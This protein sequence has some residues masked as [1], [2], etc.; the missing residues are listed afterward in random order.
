MVLAVNNPLQPARSRSQ[1]SFVLSLSVSRA[2]TLAKVILTELAQTNSSIDYRQEGL[3]FLLVSIQ[4]KNCYWCGDK[5]EI[6]CR[7]T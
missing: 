1:N 6:C 2:F 3:F 5:S 4:A 7:K